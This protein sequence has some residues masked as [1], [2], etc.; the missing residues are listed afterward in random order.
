VS[1]IFF[2]K[3]AFKSLSFTISTEPLVPQFSPIK[4]TMA[5]ICVNHRTTTITAIENSDVNAMR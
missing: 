5:F 2:V 3:V 1:I 4:P